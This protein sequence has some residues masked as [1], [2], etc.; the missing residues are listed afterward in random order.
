MTDVWNL[1]IAQDYLTPGAR[2]TVDLVRRHVPLDAG[3]R[4]LEIAP[5]RGTTALTLADEYGCRVLGVD[6]HAFVNYAQRAAIKRGLGDRVSFVRGD[7]GQL[8]VRDAAFDAAICIGAPSIVGTERCLR[9]MHRALCPGGAIVVSDWTWTAADPPPEAVP[10]HVAGPFVTLDA[11]ASAIRA[12]GFRIAHG[13]PLPQRVWDDYYAPLR[14]PIADQR[15]ADP[16]GPVDP[17]EAEMRAYDAAGAA[18]WSYSAF[19]ARKT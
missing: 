9:A 5:G 11:Y 10:P 7:G 3:A 12:A 19:V 1:Y 16:E 6:L 18:W 2:E 13:E 8:P 14:G 15:A 17:I 4:V